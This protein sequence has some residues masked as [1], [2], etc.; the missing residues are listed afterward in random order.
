[1]SMLMVAGTIFR[2]DD[3]NGGVDDDDDVV[4]PRIALFAQLLLLVLLSLYVNGLC[5]IE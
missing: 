5:N 1:M 4:E 3:D 2:F